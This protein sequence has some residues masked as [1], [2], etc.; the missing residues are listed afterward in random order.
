MT[1]GN[2]F[3]AESASSNAGHGSGRRLL[4]VISLRVRDDFL[5]IT[6]IGINVVMVALFQNM[7]IFGASLGM[8]VTPPTFFGAKMTPM[9]FLVLLLILIVLT[10]LL[11]RKMTKSWFWSGSGQPEKMTG[12]AMSF[13]INVS[14]YKILAFILGT[15][16]AGAYGGH[17]CAPYDIHILQQLCVY[18]FHQYLIHGGGRRNRDDKRTLLGALLLG[19]ARGSAF[20]R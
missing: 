17:L 4:G 16:I 18:R 11:T 20:R 13:G 15:A 14:Q 9:H 1:N 12:A 10:C 2:Q 8:S 19:A 6:T 5:A 7:K 3:L